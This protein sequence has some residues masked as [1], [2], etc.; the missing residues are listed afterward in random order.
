MTKLEMSVRKALYPYHA[1]LKARRYWVHGM[2]GMLPDGFI[3]Y[4]STA[5][6]DVEDGL[7]SDI[8]LYVVGDAQPRKHFSMESG[9][10]NILEA[11][12]KCIESSDKSRYDDLVADICEAIK[13][14]SV[15]APE[16]KYT[17]DMIPLPEYAR[18]HGRD[19]SAVRKRA[20]RG[21]FKTA[22]K[23]GGTW[24]IREDEPYGDNR[25][26]SERIKREG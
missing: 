25:L 17:G 12:C 15:A 11:V 3:G 1:D 5:V 18:R 6:A 10:V 4:I 8:T 19:E 14:T 24:L 22:V 9:T 21:G 13:A 26:A 7:C 20:I 2:G 23:F 16:P